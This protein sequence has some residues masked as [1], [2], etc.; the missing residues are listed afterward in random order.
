MSRYVSQS[1]LV[2]NLAMKHVSMQK[3][4]DGVMYSCDV[5]T[6][7]YTWCLHCEQVCLTRDWRKRSRKTGRFYFLQQG[8]CPNCEAREE[9]DS[10]AWQEV[11]AERGEYPLIPAIGLR[12]PL[13]GWDI[14]IN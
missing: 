5:A 7:V 4:F 8:R 9:I 3:D 2:L 13:H 10:L 6:P 1:G 14:R 12:Y 11:R